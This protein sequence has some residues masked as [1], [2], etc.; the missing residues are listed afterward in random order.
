MLHKSKIG[1]GHRAV[2]SSV[3]V[4]CLRTEFRVLQAAATAR[5]LRLRYLDQPRRHATAVRTPGQMLRIC[6][7]GRA[8]AR[9]SVC[10]R[11]GYTVSVHC[12]CRRHTLVRDAR[13]SIE[14]DKTTPSARPNGASARSLET[15]AAFVA[16]TR[17]TCLPSPRKLSPALDPSGLGYALLY[18]ALHTAKQR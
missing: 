7:W 16:G 18:L 9:A 13:R 17:P 12:S 15:I 14:F 6:C 3:D 10:K 5:T 8:R 2:G 1:G 4:L 11:H